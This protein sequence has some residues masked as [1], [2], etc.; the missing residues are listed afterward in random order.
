[1]PAGAAFPQQA[2]VCPDSVF[3]TPQTFWFK[4]FHPVNESARWCELSPWSTHLDLPSASRTSLLNV[5]T[6]IQDVSAT[7]NRCSL[8]VVTLY[9]PQPGEPV[10]WP[11]SSAILQLL[12]CVLFA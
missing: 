12:Q 5:R 1:M 2:F 11:S 10:P 7:G 3:F 8:A 6:A 9:L 4:T